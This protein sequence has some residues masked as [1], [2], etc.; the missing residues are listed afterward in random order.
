LTDDYETCVTAP[1]IYIEHM[2]I[3]G[4][5]ESYLMPVPTMM[6]DTLVELKLTPMVEEFMWKLFEYL[7]DVDLTEMAS[8]S[9]KP[10]LSFSS[11][12]SLVLDVTDI[13]DLEFGSAECADYFRHSGNYVR[14]YDRDRGFYEDPIH[15][16]SSDEEAA[17]KVYQD[18]VRFQLEGRFEELPDYD[19]VVFP[20]LASLEIR[21]PLAYSYL[22]KFAK[23]PISSLVLSRQLFKRPKDWSLSQYRSLR[24]LRIIMPPGLN[25]FDSKHFVEALPTVLSTVHPKLQ[26]LALA[27][28]IRQDS[29]LRFTTPSFAGNLVSLT[30]EGEY[31]QRDVEHLLQLF[32]NLQTLEICII[33]SGPIF[34]VPDLIDEYC[35]ANTAKTLTPLN[36]S[37]RV[38]NAYGQRYFSSRSGMDLIPESKRLMAP[39]LNHYRGLLI[40]FVCRLPALDMLRVSSQSVEGVNEGICEIVGTNVGLEHIDHLHHLRVRALEL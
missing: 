10:P 14:G 7:G 4:P 21:N 16:A 12:K 3:D 18:D 19:T 29:R 37:L 15:T 8:D 28:N 23:S 33:V 31:G 22:R 9:S 39:E 17:K 36:T 25:E 34:T 5:D 38:L 6:A 20:V 11:L 2:E 32:S 27:M 24:R 26:Q 40:G 1:P 30:L 35:R 13:E